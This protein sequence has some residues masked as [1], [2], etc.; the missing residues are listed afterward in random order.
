MGGEGRSPRGLVNEEVKQYG[1]MEGKGK[2]IIR[3]NK[4]GKSEQNIT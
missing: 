3:K 4:R 2:G 1:K